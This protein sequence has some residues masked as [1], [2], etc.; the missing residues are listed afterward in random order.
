MKQFD[1]VQPKTVDEAL[2]GWE[3]GAAWLGGGPI[4][5]T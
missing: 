1:Y 3:P 5:S 4:W 2:A